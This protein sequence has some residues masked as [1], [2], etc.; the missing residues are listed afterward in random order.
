MHDFLEMPR[1]ASLV[2]FRL[3]PFQGERRHDIAHFRQPL[4]HLLID[5]AAVGEDQKGHVTVLPEHVKDALHVK[6][7]AARD[8]GKID[9][10]LLH[11]HQD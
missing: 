2:G 6:G 9:A 8:N 11:L 10:H 5:Q 7:F 3:I 4:D 1:A